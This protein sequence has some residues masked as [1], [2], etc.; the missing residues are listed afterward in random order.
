MPVA[1]HGQM[2]T[3]LCLLTTHDSNVGVKQHKNCHYILHKAANGGVFERCQRT[4]K[5][6]E[7]TVHSQNNAYSASSLACFLLFAPLVTAS[8]AALP[9]TVHK[10]CESQTYRAKGKEC[11]NEKSPP[12]IEYQRPGIM[13]CCISV[14]CP[15]CME[16]RHRN[17]RK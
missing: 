8:L 12:C 4:A 7:T 9:D 10:R 3:H 11:Q 13:E 6:E 15:N 17:N 14:R 5:R 2:K 1:D 16:E